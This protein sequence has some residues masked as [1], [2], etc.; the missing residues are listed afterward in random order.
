MLE[1]ISHLL[2]HTKKVNETFF[3]EFKETHRE[4]LKVLV[5]A[6]LLAPW[7]RL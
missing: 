7:E 5:E 1:I 6:L 3:R 2:A 4:L